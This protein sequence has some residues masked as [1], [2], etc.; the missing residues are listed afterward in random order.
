VQKW[1]DRRST[2]L[3]CI[4]PEAGAI[5]F[6]RCGL[7]VRSAALAER[8]REEQSVLVAPG[9]HFDMEGYLRIGFGCDPELLIG[10]LERLGE[11]LD[12]AARA[13][14]TAEGPRTAVNAR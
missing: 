1:L 12:A 9:E 14:G 11:A 5:A 2:F 6:V 8:I 10:A 7:P 4:P 13:A 3:H